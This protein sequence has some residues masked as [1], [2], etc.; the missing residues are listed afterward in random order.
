[1]SEFT[2]DMVRLWCQSTTG[3]FHYKQILDG[4][5]N[6]KLNPKAYDKLRADVDALC[7]EKV[8]E[9]IGKKDGFYRLI[10]ELPTPVDFSDVGARVGFPIDLPFGL[11]E[12]V[13]IY[14][15]TCIIVAGSKSAGK[16]GFLYRTIEMNIN[17][18]LQI[19]LLSTMEGGKQMMKDRF[20]AMGVDLSTCP[21]LVFPVNDHFH[22][23]IK[24]SDTL[25]VIDYIDVPEDMEFYLIGSAIHKV[26]RRLNEVGNSVAVIGL[27]KP[28]SRD[29]AFGGEQTLKDATLYL[30]LN[31][32]RLK[33]VD[34][35]VPANPKVIPR[36][37]QWSFDYED[38][39]TKFTNIQRY[40]G[41]GE[42]Q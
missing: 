15:N 38:E 37:M 2:R 21:L 12:F 34:A 31:R 5:I 41:V 28:S 3:Q 26:Q 11:R 8:I 4:R 25:Y 23:Y 10:E 36:N 19:I 20:T 9:P 32:K 6:V 29:T 35:K 13:F 27:Q 18:N 40:Y 39:G 7:K 16:T 24:Y 17:K 14:P 30:A 1:M 42:E 22:D 33:I